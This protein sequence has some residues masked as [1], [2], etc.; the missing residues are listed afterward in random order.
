MGFN[1][2]DVWPETKRRGP[3]SEA[4]RTRMEVEERR[5]QLLE[6]GR[7]LFA[8]NPY[9]Q[10]SVE[11]IAER[12]GVSVGLLYHYFAG[13]R[14]FYLETL[15]DLAQ[16]LHDSAVLDP[17]PPGIER[18]LDVMNGM[19]DH[20]EHNPDAFKVLVQGG[21]ATDPEIAAIRDQM[22][23]RLLSGVVG[24]I[25]LEGPPPPALRLA[26]RGWIGYLEA[27]C[28]DWVD[29]ADIDRQLLIGSAATCLAVQLHTLGVLPPA[30]APLIGPLFQ[31]PSPGTSDRSP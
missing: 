9:D 14:G 15:R 21:R 5:A 2:G 18:F 11:Q 17:R 25:G 22:H 4:G 19:L 31:G 29:H 3:M 26:L 1:M 12:A 20:V 8:E 10:L 24:R 6:V 27:V 28:V 23:E 16:Q 30:F 7:Q 13:K